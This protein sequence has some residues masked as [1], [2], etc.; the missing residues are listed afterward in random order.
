ME[1]IYKNLCERPWLLSVPTPIRFEAAFLLSFVG[2]GSCVLFVKPVIF[3]VELLMFT[4]DAI[5]GGG[6][7]ASR[8][9]P[10]RD[11]DHC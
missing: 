1:G 8:S 10:R 4:G 5:W 6:G 3:G 11:L 7:G 9:N 2:D